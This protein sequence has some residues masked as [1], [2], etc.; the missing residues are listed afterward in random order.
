MASAAVAT[1]SNPASFTAEAR[2]A[3]NSSASSTMTILVIVPSCGL[4]QAEMAIATPV[5]HVVVLRVGIEKEKERV[6][7]HLH[8][9][10]GF[11][12]SHRLQNELLDLH[13]FLGRGW[14]GAVTH[15]F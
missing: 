7:Q 15:D 8:L 4:D 10:G 9:Q 6:V 5:E 1:T 11:F 12:D 13:D 2:A 14:F 3:R